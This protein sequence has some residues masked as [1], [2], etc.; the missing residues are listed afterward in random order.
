M[1]SKTTGRI[2]K[3]LTPLRGL[4]A[5]KP[6]EG[7]SRGPLRAKSTQRRQLPLAAMT[8]KAHPKDTRQRLLDAGVEAFLTNGFHGTGIKAVLDAVGVPKGS[9]YNYFASKEAFGVATIEHY[10]S[11]MGAQMSGALAAAPDAV[12]GL[13]AFFRIEMEGFKASEFVGGCLVANLGGE[14]EGS[15][16]IRASLAT[17]QGQYVAGVSGALAQAQAQGLVR[18]DLG[19]DQLARVLVDTWEGAVIRMKIERSLAPLEQCLEVVL[20]GFLREAPPLA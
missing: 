9:F 20:D 4:L 12:E 11:L 14:V 10:A 16:A 6:P 17:A 5:W 3:D 15:A 8:P 7:L 13:K 18:R 2:P 19:A 1:E